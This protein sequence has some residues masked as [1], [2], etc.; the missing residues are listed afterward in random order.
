MAP[1]K[2]KT[3]A[4][5]LTFLLGPVGMH[6]FYLFGF[7]DAMGWLLPLPTA[8]GWYG[9][10][11]ALEFGQDDPLSWVLIPLLGFT[12][13]G[14]ALNA[15]VYGLMTPEKWNEKFNSSAETTASAGNS[16][17][18]TVFGVASALLLGTTVLMASIV[19]SFQ[20]YF[21][22]QIEEARAISQPSDGVLEKQKH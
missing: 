9:I 1:M 11:R 21:E 16:S 8:L 5:W 12:M 22:H 18:L 15:I 10:Q 2:N 17:W 13:A 6:R 4:V 3:L 19:F 14:C 20:R 7:S